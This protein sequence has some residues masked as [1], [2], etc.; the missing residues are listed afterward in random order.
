VPTCSIS[1]I[2]SGMACR[3]IRSQSTGQQAFTPVMDHRHV[4]SF[5]LAGPAVL[6]YMV[7][8]NIFPGPCR[9]FLAHAKPCPDNLPGHLDQQLAPSRPS[10]WPPPPRRHGASSLSQPR[11]KKDGAAKAPIPESLPLQAHPLHELRCLQGPVPLG[12]GPASR[13][14][15]TLFP[16]C[17]GNSGGASWMGDG[18]QL[19]ARPAPPS[20]CAVIACLADYD[21]PS[22]FRC[23]ELIALGTDGDEVL[24]A[25]RV[26]RPIPCA[27]SCL[28]FS[29]SAL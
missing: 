3:P 18:L 29:G 28:N 17:A 5:P 8:A 24:A 27:T 26:K 2:L 21:H 9:P 13:R 20:A 14:I 11:V 4:S 19:N 10:R 16:R 23:Q 15:E 7:V 12:P 22:T 1:Q 25:R 6:L